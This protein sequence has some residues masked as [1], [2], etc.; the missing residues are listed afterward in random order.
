MRASFSIRNFPAKAGVPGGP[1]GHDLD[2]LKAAKLLLL[3][4]PIVQNHPAGGQAD[5]AQARIP[6][7]LRLLV[8]LLEH[9][10]L[11][12]GF[13]RLDGVPGHMLHRALDLA[14]LKI[15]QLDARRRQN[16]HVA[17]GQKEHIPGVRQ[18]GGNVGGQKVLLL[19]QS[20]HRR[21]P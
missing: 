11:V 17:I 21:R 1:A 19:P 8:N 7:G 12:A 20:N 15:H 2:I 9:E 5:A 10:M 13:L 4:S 3:E 16:G 18:N 14:P 6:H